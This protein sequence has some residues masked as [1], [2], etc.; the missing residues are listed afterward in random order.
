MVHKTL[1]DLTMS[2]AGYTEQPPNV[3]TM[4][5]ARPSNGALDNVFVLQLRVYYR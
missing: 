2:L 5:R 1:R 4:P 3:V